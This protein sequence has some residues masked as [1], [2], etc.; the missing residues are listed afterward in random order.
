MT[1]FKDISAELGLSVATGSRALNGTLELKAP[2]PE[3]VANSADRLAGNCDAVAED[4][5]PVAYSFIL[6]EWPSQSDGYSRAHAEASGRAGPRPK[7]MVHA[8]L[9]LRNSAAPVP[10]EG[11]S[12]WPLT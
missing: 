10:L 1:T 9:T 11:V 3:R 4:C 12:S 7:A 2:G 5:F 6:T 8:D